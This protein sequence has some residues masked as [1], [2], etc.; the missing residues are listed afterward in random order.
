MIIEIHSYRIA[1]VA[2]GVANTFLVSD[3]GQVWQ[4]THLFTPEVTSEMS[5]LL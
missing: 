1:H 5:Y 4:I 2:G 3:L